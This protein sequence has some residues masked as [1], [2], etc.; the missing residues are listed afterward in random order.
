MSDRRHHRTERLR[1]DAPTIDDLDVLHAIYSDPRVWTHFPILRHTNSQRTRSMLEGWIDEWDR[2]GLGQWIVRARDDD[3]VLGNAG[4]SLR[5][6]GW[7]NLGY[8][9]AAEVHGR[10]LATEAARAGLEA[11]VVVR[12]QAPVVAHLLE[13]NVASRRVA[14]KLGL[15]LQQQGHDVGNPDPDAVRLVYADRDLTEEQRATTLT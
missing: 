9:F 14:E 10:G 2:D 8:R 13:H 15:T 7:W 4:C 1:L 5:P 6:H 11:A 12:P 3:A